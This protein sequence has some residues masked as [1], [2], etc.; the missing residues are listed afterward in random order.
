VNVGSD[1][2]R[3]YVTD[4]YIDEKFEVSTLVKFHFEVF[5]VLTVCSIA[6]FQRFRGPCSVA[7]IFTYHSKFQISLKEEER[8]SF[9][10]FT[11]PRR[12][13]QFCYH[14]RR[15]AATILQAVTTRETTTSDTDTTQT[16]DIGT[17]FQ[18]MIRLLI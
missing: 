11:S 14:K 5:W 8:V 13:R 3:R 9:K 4:S 1:M 18:N 15:F 10:S 6:G 7:S 2:L 16:F 12:W 17:Y